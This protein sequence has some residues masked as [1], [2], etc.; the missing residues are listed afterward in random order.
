MLFSQGNFRQQV[1]RKWQ[2]PYYIGEFERQGMPVP[3]Q[4]PIKIV[5]KQVSML[6]DK[7]E[8]LKTPNLEN[9]K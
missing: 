9:F 2:N 8:H 4:S 7:I 3:A 6:E 5:L 1:L